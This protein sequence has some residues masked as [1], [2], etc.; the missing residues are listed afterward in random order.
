VQSWNSRA[1]RY[2]GK[3]VTLSERVEAMKSSGVAD[4]AKQLKEFSKDLDERIGEVKEILEI[5][6]DIATIAGAQGH[7][8]GTAMMQGIDQFAAGIDIVDK[9][10]GKLGKSV[11]LFNDLWSKW[12]KPMVDACIKGLMKLAGLMEVKDRD[13]V[14]ATWMTENGGQRDSYGS[15][16]IPPSYLAKGIFPG[17][18]AVFSY[19]HCYRGGRP[20]PPMSEAVKVFFLERQDIMNEMSSDKGGELTS[21]WKLFSPSTW[22]T[23]GRETNLATW[24]P[25]HWQTV[26]SMFYGR[27]ASY[28]P[29]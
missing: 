24:L 3:I 1:G 15:P 6:N 11:P 17:G 7:P 22:S 27:Y 28:I 21:D 4:R 26:W 9:T 18:Q 13:D 8:D 12:Y 16:V 29:Y 14:I 19:L 10:I 25:N 20:A 2:S 23:S 5:T